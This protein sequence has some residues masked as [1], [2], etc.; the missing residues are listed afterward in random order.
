[1]L[2]LLDKPFPNE[3][4]GTTKMIYLIPISRPVR[5]IDVSVVGMVT[6]GPSSTGA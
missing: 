4:M 3:F 6:V 5:S 1:M 2:T